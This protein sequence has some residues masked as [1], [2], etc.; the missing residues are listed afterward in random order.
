MTGL[1]M[2]PELARP[3]A[4]AS[5]P[6]TGEPLDCTRCGACCA[7]GPGRILILADDLVLWRR[8]GRGDLA[9]NTDEGHFGERAFPTSPEGTCVYLSRP[10]GLTLCTIYDDRASVCR[11]F[12]AGSWQCLEFR[13]DARRAGR[14]PGPPAPGLE[15]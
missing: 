5:D 3:H 11:E 10:G 14:L 9:D 15:R 6:D 12:Q 4:L 8:K 1:P 2:D 7:A 13:R